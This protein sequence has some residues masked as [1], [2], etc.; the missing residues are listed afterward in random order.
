MTT[1]VNGT[2]GVSRVQDGVVVQADLA[3]NVAGNGPAF[4]A[5]QQTTATSV[6]ASGVK[7]AF[8]GETF[9]TDNCFDLSTDRFTP[10]VAGYYYITGEVSYVTNTSRVSATIAK[11]GAGYQ[12]GS[13]SVGLR[14]MVSGLVYMNGTTDYLELHGYSESTQNT[15]VGQVST[16]FS[17]F[18]ARAA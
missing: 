14:A 7:I 13:L 18:L 4:R 2:T 3:T 10:T 17:G 11:N 16:N 1:T 6:G 9:D 5:Y 8:D 12:F 15:E